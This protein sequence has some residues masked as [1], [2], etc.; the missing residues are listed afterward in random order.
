MYY[1]QVI[2][3][4]KSPVKNSTDE[5]GTVLKMVAEFDE[6][7]DKILASMGK[8]WLSGS[9]QTEKDLTS[10]RSL[11][12]KS[13]VIHLLETLEGLFN[14]Y[15]TSLR[16]QCGV[17]RQNDMDRAGEINLLQETTFTMDSIGQTIKWLDRSD[18]SVLQDDQWRTTIPQA[19]LRH[20]T[21]V[22]N[23][24]TSDV[25]T[26]TSDDE[27][28]RIRH[29][30]AA[31]IP[32]L[33]LTRLLIKK[34]SHWNNTTGDTHPLSQT[35]PGQLA[36]LRYTA[37]HLISYVSSIVYSTEMT[38]LNPD[39]FNPVPLRIAAQTAAHLIRIIVGYLGTEC[40][41]NQVAH[42]ESK[43]WCK[44]WQYQFSIAA[45]IFHT[46][47]QNAFFHLMQV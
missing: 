11:Q 10:F 18:F 3:D 38:E 27:G 16:P 17:V 43:D 46:R 5:L 14:L 23:K 37:R 13:K 34:M 35:P 21:E 2:R 45:V 40:K 31:Y 47:Y 6:A 28:V 8:V 24:G 44:L 25:Y 19:E 30:I 22:V 15:H 33:K 26:P 20:A 29:T 41:I 36:I 39:G 4:A 32:I 42:Q 7:L 9:L 1:I 12:T